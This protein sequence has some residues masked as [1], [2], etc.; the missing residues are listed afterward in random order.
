M[1]RVLQKS[2]LTL[3]EL[4]LRSIVSKIDN[5]WYKDF[6]DNYYGSIHFMYLLGP[7]D[8]LPPDL[9]HDI[10]LC[11][12]TRRLLRKHHGYLL[13]SP[14]LASL[15]LAHSEADLGLMLLLAAQRCFQLQNLDLSHNKL[16]KEM[17]SRAVP[18][19]TQL[20]SLSLAHSSVT[21]RQV[22]VVGVYLTQLTGLDLSYCPQLTDLGLLSLV[23]PQD[24]SG[25]PDPRCGQLA[26]RLVRLQ[27][28][29]S[30]NLSSAA[31][32]QLLGG[33]VRTMRVLEF[34]D[35]ARVVQTLVT[36]RTA[37]TRPQ[38]RSL[39]AGEESQSE[40]L[41]VA[42]AACPHVEHVYL[43]TA[44]HNSVECVL[45]LLD[46]SYLRELHVRE[47]PSLAGGRDHPRLCSVLGPVVARHGATLVSLNL[48]EVRGVEVAALC[49]SCPSLVHL[50]LLW[51][52]SYVSSE[53][54]ITR[55]W[56]P[57]LQTVDLAYID[58][59]MD[60]LVEVPTNNLLQ[61]LRS[62]L[63]KSVKI[64]ASMNL[65]DQCIENVLAINPLI[66]LEFLELNKCHEV[67]FDILE[68]LLDTE[69][70]ISHV[71]LLKC[72]QISRRD[73]ENYKRKVKKWKWNIVI[74]WT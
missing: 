25:H 30:Q 58:S 36:G 11:L 35:T 45:A 13:I 8:D 32:A 70:R 59:E 60:N 1:P 50:A 48:A 73:I 12:K 46:L 7:F 47:D 69:N 62:P 65:S 20:R 10:W 66:N 9:I 16:P 19:L 6:L 18:S 27:L 54:D 64:C 34:R 2:D 4:C 31:V 21:D 5:Y 39:H 17:F 15:D 3:K 51:N 67:S 28:T 57:K 37:D 22:S 71:R 52:K 44:E 38:L 24:A 42:V 63:L 40:T 29:G 26:G 14:Y 49:A 43:V 53:A 74:D 55:E 33:C 68:S 56:F 61:I 23:L 41:A 72:E